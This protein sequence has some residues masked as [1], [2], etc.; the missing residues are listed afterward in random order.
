MKQISIVVCVAL[1]ACGGDEDVGP[2]SQSYDPPAEQQGSGKPTDATS[3]TCQQAD[4]CGYWFCRCE[5]GAVVNSALCVNGFCMGA[6]SACPRACDAFHH[7]AWT[8]EAGGGPSQ[9]PPPASCGGLGSQIVA[10]DTCMKSQCCS[11]ASACGNSS[12]C[13]HYWDCAIACDGD[14]SCKASCD[15][16]YPGG[17]VP[18]EGLRDCLLDNCY[19]QCV[20]GV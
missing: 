5:D 3:V 4:D 11:E 13:L 2:G 14:P 1:A 12:T 8:G 10:C 6:A 19:S 7:G 20:G 15:N 9:N 17:R 16:Q 18:Y